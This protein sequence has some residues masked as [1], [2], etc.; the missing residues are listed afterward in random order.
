MTQVFHEPNR[1]DNILDVVIAIDPAM[2][3][4]ELLVL[5]ALGEINWSQFHPDYFRTPEEMN[6][7]LK[8]PILEAWKEGDP[9]KTVQINLPQD[10]DDQLRNMRNRKSKALKNMSTLSAG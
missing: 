5:G 9:T 4:G 2:I 10:I 8:K 6:D 1:N 7:F 3:M